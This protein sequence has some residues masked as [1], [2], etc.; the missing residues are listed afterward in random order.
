M[1]LSSYDY[2]PWL[3][4]NGSNYYKRECCFNTLSSKIHE[5]FLLSR[6]F[7]KES[8]SKNS[9]FLLPLD[10]ESGGKQI[11]MAIDLK[12]VIKEA[13]KLNLIL[14]D[15]GISKKQPQNHET[16]INNNPSLDDDPRNFF[17]KVVN[18]YTS[19]QNTALLEQCKKMLERVYHSILSANY[20]EMCK[21]QSPKFDQNF[22]IS[23]HKDYVSG[24]DFTELLYNPIEQAQRCDT[25]SGCE[26]INKDNTHV[27]FNAAVSS[28]GDR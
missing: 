23:K 9:E 13:E 7:A 27:G 11:I 10:N 18:R 2:N 25:T 5:P 3:I 6:I 16:H 8:L 1:M 14:E 4:P 17:V 28:M 26:F 12:P 24:F 15:L 19:L 22:P 21:T 20:K